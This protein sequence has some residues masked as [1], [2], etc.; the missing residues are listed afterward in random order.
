M[1]CMYKIYT[2]TNRCPSTGQQ[3]GTTS[4]RGPGD[5]PHVNRPLCSSSASEKICGLLYFL[6]GFVTNEIQQFLCGNNTKHVFIQYLEQYSGLG[7]KPLC[8]H[9]AED[10]AGRNPCFP[11]SRTASV[12]KL[13]TLTMTRMSKPIRLKKISLRIYCRLLLW[14]I[15][16][17]H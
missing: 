16:T 9:R 12:L 7:L 17:D 15:A 3:P 2:S 11:D 13:Q 5:K 6:A 1:P 8:S 14:A 10:F 4:I